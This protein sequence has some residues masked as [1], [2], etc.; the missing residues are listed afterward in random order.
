MKEKIENK[1]VVLFWLRRHA[2]AIEAKTQMP[3]HESM[4]ESRMSYAERGRALEAAQKEAE[5]AKVELASLN[6]A[7]RFIEEN[8]E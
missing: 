6:E 1:G 3:S 2:R 4:A 5:G 7:I 8:A